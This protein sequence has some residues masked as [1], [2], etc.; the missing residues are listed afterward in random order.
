MP[1]E[2]KE[3]LQEIAKEDKRSISNTCVKILSDYVKNKKGGE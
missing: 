3:E 1:K 2:L